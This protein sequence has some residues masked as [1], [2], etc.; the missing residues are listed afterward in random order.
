ML[1]G[2]GLYGIDLGS[3]F[4]GTPW[5]SSLPFGHTAEVLEGI[6]VFLT[7]GFGSLLVA[8]VIALLT[9]KPIANKSSEPKQ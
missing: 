7:L 3:V 2:L 4:L 9:D 8:G 5:K 6:T 1:I